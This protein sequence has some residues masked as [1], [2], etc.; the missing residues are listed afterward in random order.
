M[1]IFL[2]GA[3]G[4]IG[5]RLVPLLLRAGHV[6]AGMTRSPQKASGLRSLGAEPVVCDV[7]QPE[8]VIAAVS[9][10]HPDAII[11]ELTD[12][13]DE[14]GDMKRFRDRNDRMRVEGT[15]NLLAAAAAAQAHRIV[16]QS[17]AW[18]HPNDQA[19][20]AVDAHEH[21]VLAADGVIVR[22]GQLYGPD[23]FYRDD[24]PPPPRIRVDEAARRTVPALD[25]APKSILVIA[26]DSAPAHP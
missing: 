9:G 26:E 15:S 8:A 3:S 13:P 14:A 4:V 19:R 7:F 10:F 16:S 18:E 1:R 25:A 23:T 5:V 12:L 21:A 6:V 11:D 17:I 24:P 2:A 22:Y 20:A